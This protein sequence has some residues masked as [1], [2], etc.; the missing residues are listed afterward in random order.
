M[1]SSVPTARPAGAVARAA[2]ALEAFE[3]G[4]LCRPEGAAALVEVALRSD[5]PVAS[6]IADYVPDKS[7]VPGY[8]RVR[9]GPLDPA[10]DNSYLS[11]AVEGH[12]ASFR[13]DGDGGFDV[14]AYRYLTRPV[15]AEML[16]AAVAERVC[17]GGATV[18]V[19][20]GRPGMLVVRETAAGEWTSAWWM[21]RSDVVVV[22]YG[23]WGDPDAD[24]ANL[25]VVA[26]AAE[27]R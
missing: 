17:E 9:S 12:V 3:P 24:L 27:A 10:G 4:D 5:A 1:S 26:G 16:A 7:P 21:T 13:P 8:A 19:A 6:R 18:A 11:G 14:Y 20:R 25:A 2:L 22:R 23:G 15:A